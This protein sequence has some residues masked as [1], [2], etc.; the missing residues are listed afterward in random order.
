MVAESLAAIGSAISIM[1]SAKDGLSAAIATRDSAVLREKAIEL[2][3]QIIAAQ[4]LALSAQAAQSALIERERQL[5]AEIVR[6]KDWEAEK[7]RYELS[8]AAPGCFT[9]A[10]KAGMENGEPPHQ[11]CEQ[12]YQDGRKSILQYTLL[13]VGRAETLDCHSCGSRIYLRGSPLKDH[14]APVKRAG[15]K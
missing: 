15:P 12:C 11:I 7:A 2:N 5:E 13:R 3:G 10:I 1:K 9:R 6:L 8:E 4:E 14:P